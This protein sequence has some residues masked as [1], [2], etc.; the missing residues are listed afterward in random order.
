MHNLIVLLYI[1]HVWNLTG[2]MS[3]GRS[4][5]VERATAAGDAHKTGVPRSIFAVLK[6]ARMARYQSIQWPK[7]AEGSLRCQTLAVVKVGTFPS[8]QAAAMP[9]SR[10]P[11]LLQW[12]T[13]CHP[14]L[15]SSRALHARMW[16]HYVYV[17]FSFLFCFFQLSS[18]V[19]NSMVFFICLLGYNGTNRWQ[20][21]LLRVIIRALSLLFF[22]LRENVLL[23][24][25]SMAV[26]NLC[27]G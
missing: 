19:P 11:L 26:G 24:I 22:G 10:C 18:C 27:S 4:H 12:Q 16:M 5:A 2:Q 15:P 13:C 14:L 25:W 7:P 20:Y 3:L 23:F 8:Q 9:P 6:A 21:L 17:C 1:R